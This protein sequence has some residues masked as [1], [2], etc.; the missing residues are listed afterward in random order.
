MAFAIALYPRS[1][2][3]PWSP[4]FFGPLN[5]YPWLLYIPLHNLRHNLQI[6]EVKTAGDYPR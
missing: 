2:A 5:G 3:C 4:P 1:F 6:A